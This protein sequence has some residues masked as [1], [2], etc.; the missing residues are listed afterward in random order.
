MGSP[1]PRRCSSSASG[2]MRGSSILF[3]IT[4]TGLCASRRI[5]ATSSSP[6]VIPIWASTTKRTRSASATASRAWTAIERVIVSEIPGTTRD[7]IDTVM[8]RGG[9][10]F[11]LIDTAGLRRKRRHRQG[12]E[13][14]SELRALESAERADVA[15]AVIDAAEG[16]V[17]Q[18]LA[19]ADVARKADNSTLIVLSK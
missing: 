14:Y 9:R 13:Y 19:V 15:L 2:S 1:S 12:I 5:C 18:D 7:S 11:V 10:T 8:E 16:V 17:D 6:G 3:A 4:S